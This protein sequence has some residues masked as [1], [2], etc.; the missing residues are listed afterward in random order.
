MGSQIKFLLRLKEFRKNRKTMHPLLRK[1]KRGIVAVV[2]M[3]VLG[4]GIAM[5][6]LPGPAIVVIPLGLALLA[7]EFLWAR[8]ILRKARN[9]VSPAKNNSR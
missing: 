3:T 7:T 1:T 2:G 6:V 9:M 5:I 4:L 8:R